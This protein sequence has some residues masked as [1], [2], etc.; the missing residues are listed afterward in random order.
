MISTGS[1][2]LIT[3]GLVSDRVQVETGSTVATKAGT[4]SEWCS[5]FPKSTPLFEKVIL[6]C[7]GSR[8]LEGK[9]Y[10]TNPRK[11]QKVRVSYYSEAT[12]RSSDD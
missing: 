5:N 1:L 10:S 12:L 9:R 11:V 4:G 2:S 3:Y 8:G 7:L 6:P